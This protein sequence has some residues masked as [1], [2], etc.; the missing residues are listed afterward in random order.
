M[1]S[2]TVEPKPLLL[3]HDLMASHR[4]PLFMLFCLL[5]YS[6]LMFAVLLIPGSGSSYAAFAESFKIWC[7]GYDPASGH[8]QPAYLVMMLVNPLVL[9]LLIV[10]VW[11]Q[12]LR[13]IWPSK[14]VLI[15]HAAGAFATCLTIAGLLFGYEMHQAKA[16]PFSVADL[17]TS[18]PPTEFSLINQLGQP[19]KLTDFHGKVVLLTGVYATCGY[20]CPM[21]LAQVKQVWQ[22]LPEE[23]RSELRV[24][25]ITLDPERD[26]PEMLAAMANAQQVSAPQFQFLT[27]AH[28]TVNATLDHFNFARKRDPQTGIIDHANLFLLLDRQ[29]RLAFRFGLGDDQ[30]AHLGEALHLL[31]AER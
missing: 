5:F 27:G 8:F 24:L 19:V 12:P 9:A 15:R 10:V 16:Q 23:E 31:L 3:L 7:F 6:L 28:E 21:I 30:R 2:T 29:N 26:S 14:G 4:F 1:H 25:A 18:Y 20:T 17:R 22:E 11:I 13:A